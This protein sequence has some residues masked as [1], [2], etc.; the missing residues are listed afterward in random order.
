MFAKEVILKQ[1]NYK[2]NNF[3]RR[4]NNEKIFSISNGYGI[5]RNSSA[6]AANPFS[7]VPEVI[8][9]MIP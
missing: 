1:Q 5:R 6:Y 4:N 3:L 8:G 7:D 2:L 9:H